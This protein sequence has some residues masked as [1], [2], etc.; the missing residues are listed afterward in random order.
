MTEF[1]FKGGKNSKNVDI[2]TKVKQIQFCFEIRKAQRCNMKSFQAREPQR[3][4]RFH[5]IRQRLPLLLVYSASPF[6][7][8]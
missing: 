6:T 8:K 4:K 1:R 3:L 2:E 7:E 5:R